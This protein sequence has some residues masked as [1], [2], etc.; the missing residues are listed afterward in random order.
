MKAD[1]AI[2]VLDSLPITLPT[3]QG[4]LLDA[5]GQGL[6][7]AAWH[8]LLHHLNGHS[9]VVQGHI[10][11][12]VEGRQRVITALEH[13]SGCAHRAAAAVHRG[14]TGAGRTRSVQ[15]QH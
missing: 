3:A 7:G 5:R 6:E 14:S 2:L 10:V 4:H 12:A 9:L 15:A 13:H 11:V 8:S 1:K